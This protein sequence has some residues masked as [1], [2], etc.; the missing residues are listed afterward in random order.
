MPP[1]ITPMIF[2]NETKAGMRAQTSCFVQEG[3][4]PLRITWLKNEVALEREDNIRITQLDTQTSML[5]I[6]PTEERHTGN[7]TCV[8]TNDAKTTKS[9]ASLFVSGKSRVLLF[10]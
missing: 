3:D 10:Y 6:D 5:V 4:P 7:Y 2:P 9:T 8:A 1:K